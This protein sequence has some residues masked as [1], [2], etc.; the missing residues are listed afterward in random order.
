VR[1]QSQIGQRHLSTLHR[2]DFDWRQR[3]SI[4]AIEHIGRESILGE[5]PSVAPLSERDDHGE[6]VFALLSENIFLTLG[7]ACNWPALKN[8]AVDELLETRRQ[9]TTGDS[10]PFLEIIKAAGTGKCLAQNE[11]TSPFPDQVN[12]TRH[13]AIGVSPAISLHSNLLSKIARDSN[14]YLEADAQ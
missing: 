6:Q 11:Q 8:A 12:R 5:Q 2:S 14:S 13:G 1:L 10:D 4:S 3:R 7:V 9:E